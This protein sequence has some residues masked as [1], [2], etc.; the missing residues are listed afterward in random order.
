LI[1]SGNRK[2]KVKNSNSEKYKIPYKV[3]LDEVASAAES[4]GVMGVPTLILVNK[5]GKI[6]CKQCRSVD[7]ML[8]E[9]F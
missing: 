6:K 4:Y 7:I 8:E 2:R 5:A 9:M 3:L 1:I